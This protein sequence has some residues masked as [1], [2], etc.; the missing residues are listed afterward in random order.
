MTPTTLTNEVKHEDKVVESS[1]ITIN[2]LLLEQARRMI[3]SSLM[4]ISMGRSCQ[5]LRNSPNKH[6]EYYASLTED[7][8]ILIRTGELDEAKKQRL[9]DI[10]L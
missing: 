9:A 7:L 4:H 8:L 2:D 6:Q 3:S 10:L 1:I 5:T